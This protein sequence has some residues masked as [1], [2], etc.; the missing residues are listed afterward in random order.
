MA[1]I[2]RQLNLYG[3]RCT[4]R[5]DEK[6]VFF[7]P[8]FVRGQ[9]DVV[10]NIRRKK[11]WPTKRKPKPENETGVATAGAA[12]ASPASAV[13]LAQPAPLARNSATY[14]MRNLTTT[15]ATFAQAFPMNGFTLSVPNSA[16]DE[17]MNSPCCATINATFGGEPVVE[18]LSPLS[19]MLASD[20]YLFGLDFFDDRAVDNSMNSCCNMEPE[21][22]FDAALL[23]LFANDDFPDEIM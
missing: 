7:H 2:Q 16:S 11:T 15:N 22:D 17:S 3:F 13:P 8:N 5:I 21:G 6:G 18:A 20:E 1:S 10:R 14:N 19:Q 12:A 23:S 9:Y 4:N